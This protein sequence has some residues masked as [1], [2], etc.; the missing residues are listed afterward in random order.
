M[1]NGSQ[2]RIRKI[3][4]REEVDGEGEERGREGR[5]RENTLRR[6]II[7]ISENKVI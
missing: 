3:I 5:K 1:D 4:G 6:E 2:A 7:E